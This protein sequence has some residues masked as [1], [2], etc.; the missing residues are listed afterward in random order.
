MASQE[1]DSEIRNSAAWDDC[2]NTIEALQKDMRGF[3]DVQA[4]MEHKIA[5]FVT[6]LQEATEGL[7]EVRAHMLGQFWESMPSMR[8]A[9][10]RE[11]KN[12]VGSVEPVTATD[13]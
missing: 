5:S 6:G 11:A 13:E 7:A 9:G 8:G 10:M 4:Q 1:M 2:R 12:S 3:V